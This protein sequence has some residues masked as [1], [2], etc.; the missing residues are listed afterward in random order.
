MKKHMIIIIIDIIIYMK[1]N[2]NYINSI[3]VLL[4]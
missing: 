4:K 3:D 1:K 2:I